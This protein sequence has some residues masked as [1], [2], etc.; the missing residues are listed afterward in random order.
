M[1]VSFFRVDLTKIR[2]KGAFQC[3]KCGVKISPEDTSDKAYAL[4]EPVMKNGQLER[5]VLECNR[6]GSRIWLI[7]FNGISHIC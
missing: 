1:Q 2:G 7:G 4:L 5:I 3:P 6:C